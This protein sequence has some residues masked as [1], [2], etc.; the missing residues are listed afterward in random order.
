MGKRPESVAVAVLVVAK[1]QI[2]FKQVE[3]TVVES[4]IHSVPV[5]HGPFVHVFCFDLG[6]VFSLLGVNSFNRK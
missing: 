6:L 5:A 2:S 4:S 1:R 3:T